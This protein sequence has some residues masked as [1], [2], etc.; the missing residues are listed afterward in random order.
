MEFEIK[1]Y[2]SDNFDRWFYYVVF[3]RFFKRRL[4]IERG[5]HCVHT[6]SN[7]EREPISRKGDRTN[8][9]V[10][11][12]DAQEY[13]QKRFNDNGKTIRIIQID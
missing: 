11:V 13:I 10:T 1:Q 12:D 8:F 2:W 7:G 3:G 4:K 5:Y 6:H 9:F